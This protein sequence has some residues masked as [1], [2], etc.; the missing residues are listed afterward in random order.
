MSKGLRLVLKKRS[1]ASSTSGRK[2][3]WHR[4]SEK[5]ERGNKPCTAVPRRIVGERH[6]RSPEN[7]SAKKEGE[8]LFSRPIEK[9]K[10]ANMGKDAALPIKERKA[11]KV[12]RT[13]NTVMP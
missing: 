2:R 10:H 9:E 3:S 4:P 8:C 11:P 6:Q 1:D 13:Q 5:A 7:S 12:A